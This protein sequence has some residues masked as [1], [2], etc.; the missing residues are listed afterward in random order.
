VNEV[1]DEMKD[2]TYELFIGA[3]SVLSIVN[4]VLFVI[5]SIPDLKGIILIINSGMSLI[6]IADFCYRLFS[7]RSK[8]VYFLR[9]WGWADLLASVPVLGTNILCIFRILRVVRLRRKFGSKRMIKD[10][11]ANRSGSVLLSLLFLMILVLEFGG[12]AMLT[13]ESKSPYA[14]IMN[15][16]DVLWYIYVTVTTIGYGDQYPVTNAGRMIGVVIMTV[17]VGLFGT[18]TAYIAK[19]FIKP[20][21]SQ[22]DE[23]VESSASPDDLQIQM[24]EIKQALLAYEKTNNELKTRIEDLD[25][26]IRNDVKKTK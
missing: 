3:L 18:L 20:E 11:L 25:N 13:V 23:P 5:V 21:D 19:Y 7:A 14:N 1:R 9:Q 24:K 26:F 17:G 22:A 4:L 8:S 2:T 16:S 10:F 15:A 12:L 6:F